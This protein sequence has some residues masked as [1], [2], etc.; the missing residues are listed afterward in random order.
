MTIPILLVP[1]LNCTAEVYLNQLPMLW[2]HGPV[3][4]ANHLAGET[5]AEI[6]A[7]ILRDAPPAFALVGFSM[8]GYLA[9]E[10]LRQAR[11]RVLRV[12]FVDTS[13]RP[14]APEATEVRRRRMEHARAGKFGLVIEQS[15]PA[16]VHPDNMGEERLFAVH[17]RMAEANGAQAYVRHQAAII[18]RVDSRPDLARI[19]VPAAVIVGEADQI[20]PPDAG[21]EIAAGIAGSTLTV[22]P[23][24]GHFA[25]LEQPDSVTRAL[26]AWLAP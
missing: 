8:G 9:F 20:T 13:A 11:D 26:L 3:T 21:R 17:R 1:G 16:S 19:D 15:F 12:A 18:A 14:D 24:A 6:A 7:S 10:M 25:L 23:G 22:V 4:I 2:A 5:M